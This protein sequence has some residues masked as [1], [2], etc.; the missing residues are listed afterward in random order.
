MNKA[1][2]NIHQQ[3]IMSGGGG[4]SVGCADV[5]KVRLH[6]EPLL[7]KLDGVG[8]CGNEGVGRGKERRDAI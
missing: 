5:E 3:Q 2:F 4:G 7:Q 8:G 6:Q 1:P